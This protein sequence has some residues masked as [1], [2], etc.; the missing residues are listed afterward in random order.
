MERLGPI[1]KKKLTKNMIQFKFQEKSGFSPAW[2]FW[3]QVNWI[4]IQPRTSTR[5]YISSV[6]QTSEY[7]SHFVTSLL[8]SHKS[9]TP[10]PVQKRK[11]TFQQ[12]RQASALA[13][14][15]SSH[16]WVPASDWGSA[17]S[18]HSS[19]FQTYVGQNPYLAEI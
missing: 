1:S 17:P 14:L 6:Y 13:A 19:A 8:I 15:D 3:G 18:L 10:L 4:L 16:P 7:S 5:K 9:I 12:W 11:N 2:K